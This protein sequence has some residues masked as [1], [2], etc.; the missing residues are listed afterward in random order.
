MGERGAW[1]R[2]S[3]RERWLRG[4]TPEPTTEAIELERDDALLLL[5]LSLPQP[6]LVD[7]SYTLNNEGNGSD[8]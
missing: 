6:L 2:G 8:E 5:N 1:E 7:V 4:S 3:T